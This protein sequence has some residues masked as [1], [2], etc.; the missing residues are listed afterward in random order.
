MDDLAE[1][2]AALDVVDTLRRQHSMPLPDAELVVEFDKLACKM[3]NQ[4]KTISRNVQ[5]RR[6]I[7][8]FGAPSL[9]ISKLVGSEP[10]FSF[11]NNL[12]LF[13]PHASY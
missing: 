10:P 1:Q 3:M 13:Q 4:R 8:F 9:V 5:N 11:Q 12:K 2:L 7:A 6:I